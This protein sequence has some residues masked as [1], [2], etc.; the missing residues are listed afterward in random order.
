MRP[1]KQLTIIC[2]F[3]SLASLVS[4]LFLHYCCNC[5]E[6]DFWGNI[7]LAVFGSA[8]LTALSSMV[9]YLHERR[10]ALEVFSY[11]CKHLLH[12]LNKYQASMSL[13]EKMHFFLDY[14][15]MDKS[16]WDFGFGSLD[17]FFE[18]CSGNRKYIYEKIYLPLSRF[19]QAVNGH[20]WHFRWYF[21]GSG[22]NSSVMEMFVEQLE[23]HLLYREEMEIPNEYDHSGNPISF[24]EK[25]SLETKL[26]REIAA[27]LDGKYMEILYGKVKSPVS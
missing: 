9:S 8:L 15:D 24:L 4:C 25:T 17:F 16:G 18:R 12:F 1:Y 10:N 2:F 5:G 3:L 19:N 14:H 20:V 6:A 13:E 22:K 11:Q 27:E 26:V 21:D 23:N 7:C